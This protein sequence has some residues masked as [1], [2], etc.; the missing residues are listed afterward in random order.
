MNVKYYMKNDGNFK[1][2][3]KDILNISLD[4]FNKKRESTF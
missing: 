4:K 2:T 1:D 3:Y